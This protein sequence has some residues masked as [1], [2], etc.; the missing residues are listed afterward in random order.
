MGGDT[1]NDAIALFE[2]MM[3]DIELQNPVSSR[4]FDELDILRKSVN[5]IRLKN[6]PVLLKDEAIQSLYD[7][8]IK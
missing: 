5:P 1:P 7:V 8:I 2:K 3:T 6:N 4:R